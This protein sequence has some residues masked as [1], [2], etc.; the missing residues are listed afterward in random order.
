VLRDQKTLLKTSALQ[1]AIFNSVNFS[2]I[3]TDEKGVIQIF[4]VG[5]ERMLGYTAADVL[6]KM[7][8]ADMSDPQEIIARAKALSLELGIAITPGFDALVFKSA[9]GIEDIYELTYIRKDGSRL[10]AVVSITA[11]RD[12]Q[13]AI[14]GYLLIGTDNTVRKQIEAE[15]QRL[16]VIQA[17]TNT[18]LQFTNHSLR[19]SEERLSVTLNSIGDAVIATDNAACVTLLN[20][21]AEQLTGWTQLQAAGR[22]VDDIFKIINKVTRAPATIPVIET[23]AHGTIQGLANHTILIAR[24]GSEYDIADSCA[25]IRDR[26]GQVIGAVLVFRDVTEKYAVQQA[27]RD[28]AALIQTILDT[29]V[30]GIVT[31]HAD[32]GIIETVN[33]AAERMLGYTI[34][35]LVGQNF[36]LLIP[37]FYQDQPNTSLAY[38][39]ASD[40]EQAIGHG[41]EVIGKRKDGTAF[42]I[43]MAVSEMWLGERRYFTAILRDVTGRKLAEEQLRWTEESFRLMVESV[44][45]YAIVMLDPHGRVV[46]WNSGAQRIKGYSSDE[47]VGRH[48]SL[49]Y[50]PQDIAQGKPQQV[51]DMV[52]AQGRC[53]DEGWRVRK[54]NS[55]F[56]AN[57]VFTAIRDHSGTLRGFAK[58]TQDLTRRKA[59]NKVLEDKNDELERARTLAVKANLAKSDF[60]SSM[61]HEL[62]TP[63]NAILGFA[64]LIESGIPPPSISQKRS[65]DQ[66]LKAGWYLL[67]LIN[68]ILDLAL[69]ESGKL[70]L[71]LEPVSL[72]EVMRECQVMIETQAQ[73]RG[74]AVT[75][76]LFEVPYFVMADRT[77][78][79]Q[80]IINLLSNAIKYNKPNGSVSV[81]CCTSPPGRIRISVKDTGHGLSTDK[82]AQLFQPFNRLGQEGNSEE[83]TGIGLVVCKR[84]IEWMGGV[85]EV[86][87]TVGEGSIFWIEMNQTTLPLSVSPAEI[88]NTAN[89]LQIQ[90]TTQSRTL[91]YVEDNPANLML[92][93]DLILRRPDIRL[94]SAT[95]GYS[96]VV[97]ASNAQPDVILMDIN[98][99][100]MSGLNALHILINDPATAH[101]PVVA[102]S[103]NAMPRDIEKGLEAG[104]FRYLTKPIKVNEF[105]N[106]LDLAMKLAQARKEEL[107]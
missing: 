20:P 53:E 35:E 10:P 71:S 52:I 68:E 5:A 66:I 76:P 75:F 50:P 34:E 26:D 82:I 90:S 46:S 106:T 94:L 22:P 49:F 1:N 8:P 103:A 70:S 87:S 43:E 77:R 84:L 24:D 88:S 69:I 100:G 33:P 92:V 86:E 27:L 16:L 104:F 11:L 6:N 74:I 38:Y 30:D 17:L 58:L 56:W 51:L 97:I 83:G 45:D 98:L 79:K 78:V 39:S 93:E 41:R 63:L 64:Q 25:P 80:I 14:I 73:K 47:I 28:S 18:Q 13:E 85:I 2:S 96:G 107:S 15:Q 36:S 67:E 31:L 72:P 105:I 40:E 61:S 29:V 48:F 32:S 62:R 19:L 23:L 91:L 12:E 89:P 99:P 65:V 57:E 81:Q 101:I 4:N 54:D 37:E 9:R 102:L 44:S 42:P 3:A 55:V 7:T 95:D 59:L 21:L 60:L